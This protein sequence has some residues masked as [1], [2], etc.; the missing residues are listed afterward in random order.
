MTSM[1][2]GTEG[3]NRQPC[4]EQQGVPG[5]KGTRKGK[6]EMRLE[7]ED[8]QVGVGWGEGEGWA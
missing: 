2:K 5:L 4:E 1:G 3:A 7:V 6:E 8:S